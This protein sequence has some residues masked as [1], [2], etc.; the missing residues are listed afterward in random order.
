MTQTS[1][2]LTPT[3]IAAIQDS[4]TR[5]APRADA[6]ATQFYDDLFRANPQVR[7]LFPGD[8]TAQKEKLV[9]TLAYVVRGLSDIARIEKA[10]RDLGVRHRGYKAEPAH[11]DAVG[12][13]LLGALEA[14]LGPRWTP[15]LKTAW[16][17]A[18]EFLAKTMLDAA[19]RKAAV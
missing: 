8:M 17:A 6:L 13:A 2:A 15:E 16:A 1:R 9:S 12:V 5:I 3:Q 4:F 7:A 18:Y 19:G 10:V 14:Q 11:Y